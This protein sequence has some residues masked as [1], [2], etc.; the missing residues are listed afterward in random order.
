MNGR[1]MLMSR[2]NSILIKNSMTAVFSAVIILSFSI[3]ACSRQN[4]QVVRAEALYNENRQYLEIRNCQCDEDIQKTLSEET[5]SASGLTISDVMTSTSS[6]QI[7]PISPE[8]RNLLEAEIS[9]TYAAET[10]IA[11]AAMDEIELFIPV[12]RIRTFIIIWEEQV[13]DSHVIISHNGETFRV[14]YI[15]TIS[16]PILENFHEMGCTG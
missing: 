6:G 14:T 7:V 8:I 15:Y 13:F 3:T 2:I 4:I 5:E 9:Q 16:T 10:K 1:N 11:Q 12:D